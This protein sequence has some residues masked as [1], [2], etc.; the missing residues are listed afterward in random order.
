MGRVCIEIER[1]FSEECFGVWRTGFAEVGAFST[2]EEVES[3]PKT[4][5]AFA[6]SGAERLI[7]AWRAFLASVRLGAENGAMKALQN[8]LG[9]GESEKREEGGRHGTGVC[10]RIGHDCSRTVFLAYNLHKPL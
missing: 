1:R 2:V 7:S 6:M 8:G 9:A 10:L 4:M 5:Q 3:A